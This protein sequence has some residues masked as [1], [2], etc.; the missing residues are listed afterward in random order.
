[1]N[2]RRALCDRAAATARWAAALGAATLGTAVLSAAT[3]GAAALGAQVPTPAVP[4]V[5]AFP[6][7]T[8]RADVPRA[9]P[10][11]P[12]VSVADLPLKDVPAAGNGRVFAVLFT[13]DGGWAAMDQGVGAQL[14]A[15]GISVVGFNQRSYLWSAKTPEQA[16]VDLARIITAYRA[17]WG[18]DTV[19][20]IGYSRG[21][22]I[23]PFA[24]NRLP[25]SVR[26]T[27]SALALIGADHTAGFHF[28][29]RDLVSSAPEPDEVPVMPEMKRLGNLPIICFY[30]FDET[31][32]ICPELPPPAVAV[33]MSGGHLMDGA[34]GEIG[35]R[36]AELVK[37]KR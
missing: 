33:K 5:P 11:V 20:I 32:T 18:R 2:A 25:A 31:D 15:R 24:I 14:V 8:A 26:G 16:G 27:V 21:A 13:G 19:V 10:Q 30:G 17:K 29:W 35:R 7:A 3:L 22:G 36:I 1:V 6:A 23:A 12:V 9:R 34:Y 28:R 4:A 37:G